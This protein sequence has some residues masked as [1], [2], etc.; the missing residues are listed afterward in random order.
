SILNTVPETSFSL[1]L[2]ERKDGIIKGSLRSEEYKGVNV[3]EIAH[4]FGGGG[5]RLSSGFEIKGKI[6]EKKFGWEIM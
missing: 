1:V 3:S 6:V 2:S 4:T 5:H